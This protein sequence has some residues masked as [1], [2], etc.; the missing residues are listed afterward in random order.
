MGELLRDAEVCHV[1]VSEVSQEGE[2]A[3][4][5]NAVEK[6]RILTEKTQLNRVIWRSRVTSRR[7]PLSIF[8]PEVAVSMQREVS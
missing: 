7:Q 8:E 4:L 1:E 3:S 2:W 5:V 6:A